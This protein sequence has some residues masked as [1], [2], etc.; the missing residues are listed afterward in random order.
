[1]QHLTESHS[2]KINEWV[3]QLKLLNYKPIVKILEEC[4][5][6][7]LNQ[8]EI[9]WI[10]QSSNDDCYLLNHAH[11]RTN[12]ILNQKEYEFENADLMMI[13]VMIRE[14]RIKLNLTQGDLSK[15]SNI[16][17]RTLVSI[18]SGDKNIGVHNL[19]KILNVF[20]FEIII[21]KSIK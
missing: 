11:N 14:E 16:S 19:K 8:K 4:T 9:D 21:R 17:R 1:M 18:E 12:I 13:G 20:D 10:I 2:E 3:T 15:L 7:N 6:D 5:E